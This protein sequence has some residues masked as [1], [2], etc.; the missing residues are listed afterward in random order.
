LVVF[1]FNVLIVIN[2]DV[3]NFKKSLEEK[4]LFLV[5]LNVVL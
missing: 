3:L 5:F 2:L 1:I 4:Q